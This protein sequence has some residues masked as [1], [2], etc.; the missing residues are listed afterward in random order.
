MHNQVMAENVIRIS[1]AEGASD[2]ASL[3]APVPGRRG[4][5]VRAALE[6]HLQDVA[7]GLNDRDLSGEYGKVK[8]SLPPGRVVAVSDLRIAPSAIR[9]S[10]PL[11]AH[12]HKHFDGIPRRKVVCTEDHS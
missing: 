5:R 11:L 1:E 2:F 4:G 6:R 9:H 10:I 12:N 8:A 7:V 3:V